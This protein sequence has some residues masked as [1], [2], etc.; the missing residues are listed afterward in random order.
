MLREHPAADLVSEAGAPAGARETVRD[1]DIIATATDP[2]ALTEYLTKLP[3]VA[4]VAAQG[5]TKATVVSHDGLRFDLRVVPPE[6]YGD[7]LQ[8]FTGSKDHNVALREDAVR[9]GLSISEYGVQNVETKE[10]FQTRSEEE[11]YAFLGYQFIPP[12]LRE[13][14]GELA[15]RAKAASRSWSR[16]HELRG[17]LHTHTRWSDGR[18]TVEEMANAA[19]ERG[20][21]YLAICDHSH[22]LRDGALEAQAEEIEPVAERVKPLKLLKG[23]EVNIRPDGSLDMDDDA[24]AGRDWV[25]ASLHSSFDR[26]PTERLL[27]AMENP[28]VDCIGH[29]TGRKINKRAPADVNV[30]RLIESR[31]RDRHRARDQLA[32]G[33]ARPQRRARTRCGR[34]RSAHARE[35]RRP[36]R[37]DAA[38]RRDRRRAGAARMDDRRP[39]A[40]HEAL[41]QDPPTVSFREDGQATLDW[42]ARYLERVGDLPV[43][44]TGRAGRADRAPAR[45][46]RRRSRSRL[47]TC[48]ATWT[49]C[50]FRPS[51]TGTTRASSPTSRPARPSRPSSPS[52]SPPR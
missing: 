3:W 49:R 17:D 2:K 50:S 25:V 19:R 39:G 18:N 33:P 43:L 1:L 30:E 47:R 23:V 42:V 35:Q 36:R 28:H 32:A 5:P 45:R 20:Y 7:L 11:L 4:E 48:C 16:R 38:V 52:S 51:R 29:P 6:S 46:S 22:R 10:V 8:H 40:E 31:A 15:A 21:A 9:R 24:L 37:G 13:N 12:E 27:A 44:A 26:N 14:R 34:G 41:E